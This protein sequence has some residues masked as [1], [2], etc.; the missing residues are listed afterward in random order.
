MVSYVSKIAVVLGFV[1]ISKSTVWRIM[2]IVWAVRFSFISER[3]GHV[4]DRW[5]SYWVVL[6]SIIADKCCRFVLRF[7]RLFLTIVLMLSL[8]FC[9][10]CCQYNIVVLCCCYQCCRPYRYYCRCCCLYCRYRSSYSGRLFYGLFLYVC[11][12][13]SSSSAQVIVNHS[14]R[15]EI[16]RIILRS[17]L[18]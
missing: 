6:L 17:Y 10:G 12:Y 13:Y 9:C 18:Y 4:P 1:V 2:H 15:T 8:S 11:C 16:N 3:I 7:V 14:S 5:C